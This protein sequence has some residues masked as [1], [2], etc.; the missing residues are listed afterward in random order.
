MTINESGTPRR[1]G[2]PDHQGNDE[3]KNYI[4][5]YCS[6][7]GLSSKSPNTTILIHYTRTPRI[8]VP[9]GQERGFHEY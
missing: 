4:H 9:I 1:D 6:A 3:S 8:S 2:V 5:F 7:L